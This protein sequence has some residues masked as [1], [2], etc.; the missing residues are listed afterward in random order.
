METPEVR[1]I[2]ERE[3]HVWMVFGVTEPGGLLPAEGTKPLLFLKL[4]GL[5]YWG[6]IFFCA[7]GLVCCPLFGVFVYLTNM[8][9]IGQAPSSPLDLCLA[10][11]KDVQ[12]TAHNQRVEIHKGKLVTF[13]TSEWLTLGFNWFLEGSFDAR[14]I[15][16][17]RKLC[18]NP[19]LDILI[20][21]PTS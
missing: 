21:Y 17:W 10:H 7:L 15:G 12:T 20:R 5:S 4:C 16:L 11:W 6:K 8:E 3:S 19:E 13:C 1:L 2:E 18:F 14:P 9:I